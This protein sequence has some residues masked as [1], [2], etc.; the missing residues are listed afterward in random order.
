MAYATIEDVEK[1]LRSLND[2]E[3]LKCEALLEEAAMIIDSYS[4]RAKDAARVVVSCRMVRRALG[5]TGST[6]MGATQGSMS[7]LGYS[8]SWTMGSGSAG[9]LYLSKMEKTM[10][11]RDNRIG[12]SN[13]L[14]GG[15][16]D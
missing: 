16:H 3:R 14:D 2:D 9:E 10:L 6:P 11:G 5:D 1:G 7:A 8:E 12:F 15:C 4:P 13:P